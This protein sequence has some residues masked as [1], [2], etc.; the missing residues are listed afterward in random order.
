MRGY[1]VEMLRT[2]GLQPHVQSEFVVRPDPWGATA[3]IVHNVVVRLPGRVPGKAV[4]LMAH[5]D[6][7]TT[8][9]GAADNGASVAAVLEVLRIIKGHST[10]K[11]DIVVVLTDGE[12]VG[13]LGAYAFVAK[14]AWAREVGVALNF[15]FRGNRGPAMLFETGDGNDRVVSA[16]ATAVPD[17]KGSSLLYE[18][19]RLMPNDTD[20]T[21]FKQAGV[22]GL[23][24]AVA[25]GHTSYHTTL[26][27][28]D[29]L[30]ENSLQHL[31]ETMLGLTQHFGNADLDGL[32]GDDRTFFDVP[33]IGMVS[34]ALSWNPVLCALT[35]LLFVVVFVLVVRR[36]AVRISR[37]TWAALAFVG[38]LVAG[39]AMAQLGWWS[40]LQLHPGHATLLQGD[41]YNSHWYLLTF[42]IIATAVL[43]GAVQSLSR[44]ITR[45][46]FL[47]GVL[48]VWV[49]L[50]VASAIW[51]PGASYT[52][53]WPLV[54]MLLVLLLRMTRGGELDTHLSMALA[55]I[56]GV[57]LWIPLTW[58]LFV[59][60]TPARSFSAVVSFVLLL[61]LL[62]P[63]VPTIAAR[64]VGHRT[65]V[66]LII[67]SLTGGS[68]S[69]TH[70]PSNPIQNSL[71][72]GQYR[73]K[74][75]WLSMDPELDH[76]TRQF[77]GIQRQWRAVPEIF[78]P[79]SAMFWTASAPAQLPPPTIK[80]INER[81]AA[82]RRSIQLRI[83]SRRRAP[84]LMLAVEGAAVLSSSLGGYP[85]TDSRKDDW[86]LDAYATRE[87]GLSVTLEIEGTKPVRLRL[88][89]V[90]YALPASAPARPEDLIPKPFMLNGNSIATSD[91][92]H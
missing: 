52:L 42:L 44:W 40:V 26:D 64:K 55:A 66:V 91:L 20:F 57:V 32:Q 16:Y 30:D 71:I 11:N 92:W 65:T 51:L 90:S 43:V 18:L 9:P 75:Y 50:M 23:N 27:R 82:N 86:T 1:L 10:L 72:Y 47:F 24:I 49:V 4:L 8:G 41:T 15:E 19:Y 68:L 28:F 76:W 63:L 85:L 56:P 12:E 45:L 38:V 21:L 69:S 59:A 31:G 83:A 77:M 79:D 3:G 80:V 6:S 13:L 70:S 22:P 48:A 73:D 25:E 54:S 53:V 5:Y 33:V 17:P 36:G 61:G 67:L 84:R 14:H 35:A 62:T 78:G 58:L 81:L 7:V 89:D 29:L 74:A 37:A 88:S 2:L 34:Y 39:A 60:L 46:E 87:D